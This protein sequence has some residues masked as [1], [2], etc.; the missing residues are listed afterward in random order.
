MLQFLSISFAIFL[1]KNN[2]GICSQM[3]IKSSE[4]KLHLHKCLR[5]IQ[6]DRIDKIINKR[7]GLFHSLLRVCLVP[8]FTQKI[9]G[10]GPSFYRME[11]NTMQNFWQKGIHFP[12]WILASRGEKKSKNQK[13]LTHP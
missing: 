8:H 6:D 1:K 4:C 12:F 9:L 2:E 13:A 5:H 11:L 7:N 10:L 3:T